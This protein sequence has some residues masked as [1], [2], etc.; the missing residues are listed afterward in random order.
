RTRFRFQN[1][2]KSK[3]NSL[4]LSDY[5][6]WNKIVVFCGLVCSQPYKHSTIGIPDDKVERRKGSATHDIRELIYLV[7]H[8]PQSS[9]SSRRTAS[10]AGFL[11]LSQSGERPLR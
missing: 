1:S 9:S 8:R 2:L 4:I 7:G 10:D 6:T 3:F 5:A 11:L